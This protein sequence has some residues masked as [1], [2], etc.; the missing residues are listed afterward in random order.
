VINTIQNQ[1]TM[2]GLFLNTPLNLAFRFQKEVESAI[3]KGTDIKSVFNFFE[4]K[5][6]PMTVPFNQIFTENISGMPSKNSK[7]LVGI[8]P[9]IGFLQ[10]NE[11]YWSSSYETFARQIR[12]FANNPEVMAIVIK[13]HTPGGGADGNY[14]AADAVGSCKKTILSHTSYCFSAGYMSICPSKKIVLDNQAASS[15]GSIGSLYIHTDYSKQLEKDGVSMKI[16]RAKGSEKK[17][18][19]NG[20]EPLTDELESKIQSAV[21]DCRTEFVGYVNRSRR[22][23]I[24]SE[25]LSGDEFNRK[26]ALAYGLVDA[27]G[28]F[29]WTLQEAVRMAM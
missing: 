9:L 7:G 17:A 2:N 11:S 21:D 27:V 14:I 1:H 12:D 19:V 23:V 25:A 18:L 8:V 15:I 10:R 6:V 29:E 13:A 5:E 26:E 16:F 24:K 20:I 3:Q 4:K 22:G 28:S